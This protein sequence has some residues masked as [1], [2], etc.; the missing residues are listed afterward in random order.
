LEEDV[1]HVEQT[2]SLMDKDVFVMR[3]ISVYLDNVELVI[4]LQLI[5]M[6]IVFVI[7]DI[8]EIE[9]FVKNVTILVEHVVDQELINVLHVLTFLMFLIVDFVLDQF[10]IQELF[11][12]MEYVKNVLTFAIIVLISF[13]VMNVLKVLI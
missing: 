12:K 4:L 11:Y 7:M 1:E 10:V 9:I 8:M 5:K 6:V 3:D 2:K 13:L